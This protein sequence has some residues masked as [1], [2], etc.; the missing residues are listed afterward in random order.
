MFEAF[1]NIP[2]NIDIKVNDDELITKV[3]ELIKGYNREE[4]T[5]WGNFS[6]EVTRKCYRTV[7]NLYI[8]IK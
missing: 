2:V 8:T 4:Y 6:D 1:P 5:V 7:I 3:S